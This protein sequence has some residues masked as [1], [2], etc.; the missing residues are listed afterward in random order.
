MLSLSL[1]LLVL[2]HLVLE[3]EGSTYRRDLE[4]QEA[5]YLR[6]QNITGSIT[7]MIN[8]FPFLLSLETS[9]GDSKISST[10]FFAKLKTL[11]SQEQR[12]KTQ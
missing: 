7:D 2:I 9:P 1:S 12:T 11:F 10:F 3:P 4:S 6:T 5:G 8:P